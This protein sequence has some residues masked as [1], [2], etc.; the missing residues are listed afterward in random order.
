MVLSYNYFLIQYINLNILYFYILPHFIF[1][2]LF[3]FAVML[4]GYTDI[5]PSCSK[6]VSSLLYVIFGFIKTINLNQIRV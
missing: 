5:H 4:S 3:T 6:T 2:A 1:F